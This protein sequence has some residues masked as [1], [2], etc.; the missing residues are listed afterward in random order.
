MLEQIGQW[1]EN[2]IAGFEIGTNLFIGHLPLERADVTPPPDRCTVLLENAGGGVYPDVPDRVDK[3][4]QVYC[5]AKKYTDAKADSETI[6]DQLHARYSFDLP[7]YEHASGTEHLCMASHAQGI[8]ASIGQDKGDRWQ[9]ST[10]YI[11][12]IIDKQV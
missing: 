12:R 5:R 8:P 1:I 6:Y 4:L 7:D 10:N 3:L 9:F 2:N 11:L